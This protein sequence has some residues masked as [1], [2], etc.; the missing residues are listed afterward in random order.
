MGFHSMKSKEER[1]REDLPHPIWRGI[2]IIML[3]LV[4]ILSFVIADEL[5]RYFGNNVPEFTLP[6][7]MQRTVDIPI[8]GE[9]NDFF[10]VLA[11]TV[12]IAIAIFALFS[13]VNAFVYRATRE[14]NLRVFESQPEKY[15]KKRK[16]KK[17]KDRYKK[18]DEL[19]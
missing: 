6:L 9:V 16:L 18:T 4:P 11:F 8:Y 13:I 5:I 19:F 15:K 12:I 3:V 17:A 10:G 2:G 1:A 14:Q 7:E